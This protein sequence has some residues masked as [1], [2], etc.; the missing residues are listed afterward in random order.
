MKKIIFGIEIVIIAIEVML[1][2]MQIR[3]GKRINEILEEM[4]NDI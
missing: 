4:N 3:Q 1:N 2:I